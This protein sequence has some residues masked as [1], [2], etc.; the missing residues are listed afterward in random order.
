[1]IFSCL[2]FESDLGIKSSSFVQLSP[3]RLIGVSV[4]QEVWAVGSGVSLTPSVLL[5]STYINAVIWSS[6]GKS[7]YKSV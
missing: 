1:M 2:T 3:D 7:C 4:S 6:Q 5:L